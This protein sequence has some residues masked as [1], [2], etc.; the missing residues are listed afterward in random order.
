MSNPIDRASKVAT[1]Y[2]T[3]IDSTDGIKVHDAADSTSYAKVN[4]SGLEVVESSTSVAKFGATSRIGELSNKTPHIEMNNRFMEINNNEKSY[5]GAG[6]VNQSASLIRIPYEAK[7]CEGTTTK[8]ITTNCTISS[9]NDKT[10]ESEK[11]MN[12]TI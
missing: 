11:L 1:N 9:I 12:N 8:T 10:I 7:Y 2:I 5:F 6:F 4:S 3:Y